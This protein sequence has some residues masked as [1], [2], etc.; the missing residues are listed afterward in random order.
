MRGDPSRGFSLMALS[1]ATSIDALAV[2]LSL[3]FLGTDIWW[4]STAIGVI[5]CGFSLA[6][7]FLGAKMNEKVGNRMELTGGLILIA[8]GTQILVTHLAS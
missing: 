6:G 5:T 2:G 1:V 3:A 8:I 7:V 4:P